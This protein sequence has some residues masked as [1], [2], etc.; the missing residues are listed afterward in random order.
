LVEEACGGV[1]IALIYGIPQ[2]TTASPEAT[3]G[4]SE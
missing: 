4:S 1:V 2:A 3:T